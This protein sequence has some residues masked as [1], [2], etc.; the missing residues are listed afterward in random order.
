MRG[1]QST[2]EEEY[3]ATR[4][5]QFARRLMRSGYSRREVLKLGVAGAS[6]AAGLGYLTPNERFFVRD[7]TATPLIDAESWSLRL[8]GDGLRGAPTQDAPITLNY[9]RLRSL[10]S[11]EVPAFIECAG[12]GR[13]FFA[14]QEGTPAAAGSGVSVRSA[15]ATGSPC[16]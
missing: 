8:G 6:V 2:D 16:D 14:S 13:S 7:H 12:N 15:W 3:L 11:V 1:G 10:P 9:R 4:D 5:E